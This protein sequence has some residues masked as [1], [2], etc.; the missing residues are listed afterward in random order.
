MKT[1]HYGGFL[2]SSRA[3]FR[4]EGFFG[5]YKGIFPIKRG[6]FRIRLQGHGGGHPNFP[7]AFFRDLQLLENAHTKGFPLFQG[8][9]HL[10]QFDGKFNSRAALQSDNQP[11]L[12]YF[13]HS[14]YGIQMSFSKHLGRENQSPG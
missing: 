1:K 6:L 13:S 7:F 14:N 8:E 4:T 12:G 11:A 5:F 9:L 2:K 3:I 10:R